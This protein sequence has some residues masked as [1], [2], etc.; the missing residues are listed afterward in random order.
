M[1]ST[2]LA[3]GETDDLAGGPLAPIVLVP[4]FWFSFF[5]VRPLRALPPWDR[6]QREKDRAGEARSWRSGRGKEVVNLT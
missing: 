1:I 3:G 2:A 4:C 5:A 6:R